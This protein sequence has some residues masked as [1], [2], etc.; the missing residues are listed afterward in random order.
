MSE[1]KQG[2]GGGCR[3]LK[4][5]RGTQR[6]HSS[7][8]V[9]FRHRQPPPNTTS[10]HSPLTPRSQPAFMDD[11]APNLSSGA[12]GSRF[13]S[14][15]ELETAKARRDEQWKAAYAR[16]LSPP[17]SRTILRVLTTSPQARAGAASAAHR[18]RL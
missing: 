15:S 10:S 1:A 4:P 14:Q 13:V 8:S 3:S 16:Y 11:T 2:G 5:S 17:R 9:S 12:V 6:S 18:G 7:S